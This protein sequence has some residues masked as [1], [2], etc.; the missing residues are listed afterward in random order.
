MYW[1]ILQIRLAPGHVPGRWLAFAR[2]LCWDR[3]VLKQAG[4]HL[5]H[6]RHAWP[7]SLPNARFLGSRARWLWMLAWPVCFQPRNMMNRALHYQF[8]YSIESQSDEWHF[9]I[10]FGERQTARLC[11][12]H[13]WSHFLQPWRSTTNGW[14]WGKH[15]CR[16]CKQTVTSC[17]RQIALLS[18]M[19]QI[20]LMDLKLACTRYKL[21]Q[22]PAFAQW[23][24]CCLSTLSVY[25]RIDAMQKSFRCTEK[26]AAGF[27]TS[28][29][30]WKPSTP[31]IAISKK[32]G[33]A[34]VLARCIGAW[35][36]LLNRCKTKSRVTSPAK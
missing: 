10:F 3:H 18:W 28:C 30:I 29:L 24:R 15:L 11:L 34:T 32:L 16:F 36:A 26:F 17:Q 19:I 25:V 8:Q 33:R 1:L 35:K 22:R 13:S 23:S 21:E 31:V 5:E 2:S 14:A 12:Q 20:L 7:V 27:S 4:K 9:W 6:S